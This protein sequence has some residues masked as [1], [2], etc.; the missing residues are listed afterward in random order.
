MDEELITIAQQ[1]DRDYIER[2]AIVLL[3]SKRFRDVEYERKSKGDHNPVNLC[4]AVLIAWK[5]DTDPQVMRQ[6]LV[7]A[8][9]SVQ[10]VELAENV[11]MSRY[12]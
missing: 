8:L 2:L 10:C 6:Q 9:H 7:R 1:I 11:A 12:S 4:T 3:G 5:A